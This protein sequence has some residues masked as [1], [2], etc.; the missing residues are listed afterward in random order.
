MIH[1]TPSHCFAEIFIVAAR[2]RLTL[3]WWPVVVNQLRDR[4]SNVSVEMLGI[5][6]NNSA[7]V[8]VPEIVGVS[9]FN[10]AI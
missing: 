5:S 9:W 3:R 7:S 4:E 2:A 10:S 1:L 8:G 6:G